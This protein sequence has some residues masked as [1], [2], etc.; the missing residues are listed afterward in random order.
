ME[1]PVIDMIIKKEKTLV[2]STDDQGL[3]IH[4]YDMMLTPTL[5]LVLDFSLKNELFDRF[6]F[7]KSCLSG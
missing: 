1:S 6:L 2:I 5:A 7:V 4:W 3:A